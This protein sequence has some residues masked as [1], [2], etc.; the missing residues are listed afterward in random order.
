MTVLLTPPRLQFFDNNG[1]PLSLGK[2]YTYIAGT[3]TPKATFTNESGLVQN[4][5]PIQLDSAGRASIWITGSYRIVVEDAGGSLITDDDNITSFNTIE[6]AANS[7]FQSFS[8]TGAQTVFT[9]SQDLGTDENA[10]MVFVDN[11]GSSAITNTP[12]FQS[13][14]ASG[15]Q[16][17]YTLSQDLGTDENAIMVFSNTTTKGYEPLKPTQFTTSGTTLTL[18]AAPT[19]T[20]AD[21]VLVFKNPVLSGESAISEGFQVLNPNQYT[22]SGTSL[23]FSVAPAS[24]VANILVFAPSTL[25]AAA[26]ASAA[27]AD[28]SA[29]AAAL[30][31]TSAAESAAK[32]SGT[33]STSVAIG[34]GTKAFTTEADKFFNGQNVRV[35]SSANN[36]NFM[37]G[38]ATYSGT[39]LSVDVTSVGGSGTFTDWIVKVNGAKGATGGPV[40]DGSYG[41]IT[42]TGGGSIWTVNTPVALTNDFRLTLT[43]GLP[44]TTADVTGATTLYCAPYKGNR[45]ALYDGS[46]WN[47]RT[48]SQFSLALGTLTS[49]RPYDVFCYDNSTVPTL[50]FTAWTNDS[51]RATALVYQ[52]GVLVKSGALTRRY[53]G[54]FYTTSTTATEDSAAK[55]LLY[56]YYNRVL[57]KMSRIES[58]ASWAYST[59]AFRQ[60]N[61][62]AANQLEFIQGVAEDIVDCYVSSTAFSSATA[63]RGII[64]GIGLDSTT[65]NSATVSTSLFV[66]NSAM[67]NAT[68]LYKEVP[69]AGRHTLVW[70]E[71]GAGT[72]TQTWYSQYI[73]G[74][75]SSGIT[76]SVWA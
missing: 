49:G 7:Y 3:N 11:G 50:E 1:N 58:T 31:A 12:F 8:G 42:V 17:V 27:A 67:A 45:I 46:A 2:V 28:A 33:S 52:D 19:V 25:V 41:Q 40:S 30:S 75:G 43:T 9:L 74:V 57:R 48:S 54:T 24:G 51:T 56:N 4:A 61:G 59:A 16:T 5:N 10:I 18:T 62:A 39:S 65:V 32:L 60:A 68:A 73:A 72:D 35:Y 37:D 70:L 21:A 53:L 26:S 63:A 64:S 76:G 66:T 29:D 55:R 15:G 23:T 36:A 22:L 14:T 6:D 13:L 38:L 34:T 20:G 71:R 69:A 44:V 47:V